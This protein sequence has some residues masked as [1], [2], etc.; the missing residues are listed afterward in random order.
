MRLPALLEGERKFFAI[1]RIR[2]SGN[3]RRG[4]AGRYAPRALAF[5][6]E[7]I[8]RSFNDSPRIVSVAHF[9]I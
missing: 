3:R 8:A 7:A 6:P 4:T 5:L 1:G 9:T 2:L